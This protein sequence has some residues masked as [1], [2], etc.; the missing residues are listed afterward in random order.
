MAPLFQRLDRICGIAPP[1]DVVNTGIAA[2][3][4]IVTE[5]NRRMLFTS[6]APLPGKDVVLD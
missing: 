5:A 1:S 2:G 6:H 4:D 3:Q